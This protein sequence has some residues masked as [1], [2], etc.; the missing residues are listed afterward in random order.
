LLPQPEIFAVEP[1][2]VAPGVSVDLYIAGQCFGSNDVLRINGVTQTGV[3]FLSSS[4]L[5]RPGFTPSAPGVYV[6]ELLVA[7][8]VRSS[9][10]LTCADASA[11]PEVVLQGPPEDPPGSPIIEIPQGEVQDCAPDICRRV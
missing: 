1:A 2:V 3:A 8:Q 9:F 10:G 6:F 5:S 11:N 7:G 4:L